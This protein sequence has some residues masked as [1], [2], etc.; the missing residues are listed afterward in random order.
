VTLTS[1]EFNSGYFT[2]PNL[3]QI[4]KGHPHLVALNKLY[5]LIS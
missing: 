3:P 2:F 5:L 4:K 1:I